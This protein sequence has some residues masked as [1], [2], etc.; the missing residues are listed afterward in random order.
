MYSLLC[1]KLYIPCHEMY[2]Q[3]IGP[4]SSAVLAHKPTR[5][6]PRALKFRGGKLFPIFIT[7]YLFI[8]LYLY[9]F[10]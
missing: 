3:I 8:Y 5:P 4:I 7:K 9:L 2:S 1:T 10:F 6:R